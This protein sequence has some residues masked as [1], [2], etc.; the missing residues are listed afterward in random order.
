MPA[1]GN[2]SL[3][4]PI[5]DLSDSFI[6]RILL[7]MMTGQIKKMFG[8]EDEDSPMLK[9]VQNMVK[10]MPLRSLIM[11]SNGAVTQGTLDGLL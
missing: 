6:G 9:M 10:E 7:N 11:M 8:D 3:N 1:K 2:Y 4:T 5:G